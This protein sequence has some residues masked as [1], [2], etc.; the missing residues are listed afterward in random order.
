[1]L[2]LKHTILYIGAALLTACSS[3]PTDEPEPVTPP[4]PVTPSISTDRLLVLCEG[5][6][7]MDNSCIAYIDSTGVTNKWFQQNNPGMKLG[8]TGNDI[9]LVNDT[10]IAISVNW[11]NI[12][13]YI[14]PSGKAITATED[15]PN[16]RRLATDGRYLYVTSYA[17]HGYVA[18]IDL[19]TKQITDTCHTGYEPEGIAFYD[20]RLYV[21]NTGGYSFQEKDHSYESTVSVIDA[22]TM[23]ELRRIDTGCINL[24]GTV[25][26][27]G[28]W[29]CLNSAGDY[30][31]VKPKTVVLNMDTEAVSVFD[32]PATYNTVCDGR[33]YTIGSA[34]SYIT[35]E[36]EYSMHTIDVPSLTVSNG[37]GKYA[38][39]EAAITEMQAPYGIYISPYTD[40]L[41]VSDARSNATN[42]YLYEFAADGSQL[43]KLLLHGLNP[44]GF[45]AL[46][47]SGQGQ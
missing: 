18:K 37:L 23:T 25:S 3:S 21:A 1:M 13:Q 42:G 15:I 36:Y 16:N 34:F 43:R 7:G 6:W 4:T 26:Q 45:L 24:Y 29:L 14:S 31:N 22:A 28:S 33:F 40:H 17:D 12:I 11:S 41:Y 39:A 2:K 9:L 44:S 47:P 10:L 38:P 5:L 20:G 27:S 30:Y 35:L 32:F 8:D 19:K 46:P